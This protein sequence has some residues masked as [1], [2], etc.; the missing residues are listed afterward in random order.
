MASLNI[1]YAEGRYR[2]A[3][4]TCGPLADAVA[5]AGRQHLR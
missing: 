4:F 1:S 5:Y 3:H 2:F